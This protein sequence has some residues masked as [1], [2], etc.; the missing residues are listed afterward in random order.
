MLCLNKNTLPQGAAAFG[1]RGKLVLLFVLIKVFP[2]ILIAWVAWNQS[3]KLAEMLGFRYES[4]AELSRE[5]L[6]ETGE[7]AVND[8]VKALDERARNEIERI[9]TDTA[10]SIARFLHARDQ[11]I[12]L[13][14]ALVPDEATY[15][16]FIAHRQS[17]L[18][19][20]ADW[21]LKP[22]GSGWVTKDN[23]QP[24]VPVV[25]SLEANAKSFHSYPA[26]TNVDLKDSSLYLE[27]TFIDLEGVERL[28]VVKSELFTSELKDISVKENTFIKAESYFP[29]LKKLKPG[30]IYVSDVIGAYVPSRIIGKYTPKSAK[31]A[32]IEFEPEK[33]AYAGKENPLG[34]RFQGIIRWAM[35]V[36]RN[37]VKV[38][39][40]SLALDHRHVM[41]F[42]DHIMPT[43]QRYTNTPDA[44]EGN[45]A[46]IW[47]YKGRNIAHPRHYFIVGYDP[48]T[49]QPQVP[50]LE[51][52][53][54]DDWQASGL[55][56]AEFEQQAATFRDQ[57]LERKPAKDL[58]KTGNRAL[59]CRYL[60]F[61]PQCTGWFDLTEKGGSGSFTIY[62]S[63]LWK[64]TTAAPIP[65]FTG[66]YG[67]SVRGFGFVTVGAN[68][69][70]FHLAAVASRKRIDNKID[71]IDGKIQEEALKGRSVI[72]SN[73]REMA[74]R[75][76][77]ST[78][79]MIVIV[80]IIA[81]WIASYL[82]QRITALIAGIALFKQGDRQYRFKTTEKDEMGS[83]ANAF[84]E[85]ADEVEGH[86]VQLED[87]VKHRKSTEG[88]LRRV[89]EGL[90]ESVAERTQEL[91]V[92][93]EERVK[94]EEVVRHIAHHDA[95][96]GLANRRGFQDQLTEAL[97]RA[98]RNSKKV[99]LMLFDLDGFKEVND[100]L[101]HGVGD[102]LLCAVAALLE[103]NIREQ[104]IVARLGGDEFAVVMTDL[105]KSEGVVNTVLRVID[106]LSQPIPLS[107]HMIRTGTSVG[108]TVYPEDS[109][110]PEQLMLHADLAMYQAKESGGQ[111]YKFFECLMHDDIVLKKKIENDLHRAIQEG[112]FCL[113]FQPRYDYQSSKVEGVEALIRWN[114]PEKGVLLPGEFLP[115]AQRSGLLPSI[116]RWVIYEAC[117]KALKW[118]SLGLSFGRVAINVCATELQQP[119]FYDRVK[120][121]LD[122]SGLEPSLFEIEITER[123]LIG[124]YGD[125]V[126]NLQKLRELNVSVALDD[127]GA[128]HSSLQRLIECPIDVIKI[129]RFFVERIGEVKSEA[130]IAALLTMAK[131]TGIR[132]VA[133]G[134]ETDKQLDFLC[135]SDCAVIQ[136]Y[137][138]AK[139]MPSDE[140]E[141]YLAKN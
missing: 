99:S 86:L 36:T 90:E 20:R 140:L 72:V 124:H 133:E 53:V 6:S 50:W 79:L 135:R 134:V 5:S 87:E 28:K 128:E 65:Y 74:E 47:D 113:Y 8:A 25:S 68:V 69:N 131:A 97:K 2:L 137:L 98:D 84:D 105:D 125:V 9:T 78:L 4:L 129:D 55:S 100:T 83:L 101:G 75:L 39:Y 130:V 40:V 118:Q 15:Q 108:I 7:L 24:G 37:G 54:Y 26:D 44:S 126:S 19:N 121:V 62:W 56:Y 21:E 119:D 82:T 64:L 3:S 11:D 114:H 23:K 16:T 48:E 81:T 29:A 136:G 141:D 58:M 46:F 120:D 104:D 95:L 14:A 45:Y 85:M 73:L 102:E 1:M 27:M 109:G 42:T 127:L 80:I 116:E 13:A 112:E 12:R 67:N 139:P 33:G 34:R 32:G 22:D 92:Q 96:T 107:G 52:S 111:C 66:Q 132:V 10:K 38:G 51:Q 18:M 60:N 49:G 122:R 117:H 138:H 63:G 110:D 61:A 77:A 17:K 115:V 35:P 93:I 88:E 30:D 59:D 43:E 91:L 70:D 106:T 71:L 89:Q 57:S 94:A 76:T 31:K 123:A 41:A 103:A